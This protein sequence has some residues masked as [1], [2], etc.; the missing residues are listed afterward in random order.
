MKTTG[1]YIA[2]LQTAVG[3]A[4]GP[5]VLFACEASPC[6]RLP[7]RSILVALK[8]VRL[9]WPESV[10]CWR[11]WIRWAEPSDESISMVMMMAAPAGASDFAVEDAHSPA[12][13]VV[14]GEHTSRWWSTLAAAY[15][16]Q[17]VGPKH[18]DLGLESAGRPKTSYESDQEAE[19]PQSVDWTPFA[20][21][22][23]EPF[24]KAVVQELQ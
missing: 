4:D 24:H 2:G 9:C 15:A 3:F 14:V 18:F 23:A 20:V 8:K 1:K 16:S 22:S 5:L 6:I 17:Y 21:D 19:V 10:T 12:R 11:F 13:V 7:G